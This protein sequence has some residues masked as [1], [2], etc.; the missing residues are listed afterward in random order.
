MSP[1]CEYP[2]LLVLAFAAAVL[3][4]CASEPV[5]MPEVPDESTLAEAEAML[6]EAR[7]VGAAEV[8]SAP[9]R[10]AQR[11]LAGARSILYRAAA[12]SRGLSRRE[13]QRVS[14][15]VDEAYLDARL[16]LAHTRRA[17]VERRLAELEAEL[18]ALSVEEG[19]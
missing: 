4:G 10:E 15:L 16:A 12:A 6:D 5:R 13:G 3:G 17:E 9:L 2:R 11:R 1:I 14:R 18:T 8:A 19:P 7:G